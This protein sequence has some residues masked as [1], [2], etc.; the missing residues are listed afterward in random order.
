MDIDLFSTIFQKFIDHP[1]EAG[2]FLTEFFSIFKFMKGENKPTFGKVF[3]KK[4]K[5][6]DVLE[7]LINVYLTDKIGLETKSVLISSL[8]EFYSIIARGQPKDVN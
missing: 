6:L 4:K 1:R 7:C 3:I 5:Y 2:Q 8:L